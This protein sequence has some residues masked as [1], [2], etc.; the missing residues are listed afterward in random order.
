MAALEYLTQNSLTSHPF[1][2]GCAVNQ[3]NPIGADWFYDILFTSFDSSLASVYIAKIEKKENG[4]VDFT[5][6]NS[7]TLETLSDYVV[8]VSAANLVDHYKNIAKSFAYGDNS[9]FAVKLVLGPGLIAKSTF[10]QEYSKSEAE[11]SSATITMVSPRLRNLTFERY[12]SAYSILPGNTEASLTT[13]LVDVASF[14]FP[15]VP[16]ISPRYNS[17]FIEESS[18]TGILAVS[19]NA[20]AGLYNDC[21]TP[22]SIQNVYSI[23][24]VTPNSSGALFLNASSCYT[25]STLTANDKTNFDSYGYLDPYYNFEI[26]TSPFASEDRDIVSLNKTLVIQNFCKPK[27][28]PENMAAFAYYLNRVT[29]GAKELDAIATKNVETRGVGNAT[30]TNFT[31]SSFCTD[32]TFT[33]CDDS[34]SQGYIACG[35]EFIKYFHEGRTLQLY[36]TNTITYDFTIV[37]VIDSNTVRLDGTPPTPIGDNY[38]FRVVD[39]GVISNMNCAAVGYNLTAEELLNPYFKVSYTTSEAFNTAGN[40]VTYL[41]VVAALFNPSDTSKEIF[42]N[43][44][45]NAALTQ[46]GNYKV[47]D[48]EGVHVVTEPIATIPCRSYAFIEVIYYITC[49]EIG[50]QLTTSVYDVTG[51]QN[52]QIGSDYTLPGIDGAECPG[53]VAGSSIT[54]QVLNTETE[55]TFSTD[56]VDLN[57]TITSTV[58]ASSVPDWLQLTPDYDN[59]K[60]LLSLKPEQDIPDLNRNYTTYFRSYGGEVPGVITQLI[61]VYINRPT[62]IA[63][64]ELIYNQSSPLLL[65]RLTT[66]TLDLPALQIAAENMVVSLSS[67]PEEFYY[68]ATGSL[69]SG[70][71]FD[72][73][74]GKITGKLDSAVPEGYVFDLELSAHNSAGFAIN[75]QTIYFTV[76]GEGLPVMQ[77]TTGVTYAANNLITYTEGS[78]LFY[79]DATNVPIYRYNIAGNSLPAGLTVVKILNTGVITGRISELV[80]SS[81]T[82]QATAVNVYGES[83]PITFTIDYT[84]YPKPQIVSPVNLSAVSSLSVTEYLP[85]NPIVEFQVNNS[86]TGTDPTLEAASQLHFAAYNLPPGFSI[87]AATG[88]VTGQ[89]SAGTIPTGSSE[90]YFVKYSSQFVV[91]NS[92]GSTSIVVYI[93][94]SESLKPI[95]YSIANG[96][97]LPLIR[98]K[99][100]VNAD[101]ALLI[102]A[103]NLPNSYTI[104]GLPDGLASDSNAVIGLIDNLLPAGDYEVTVSATNSYGTSAVVNVLLRVPIVLIG[105]VD[106]ATLEIGQTYN[107]IFNVPNIALAEESVLIS[108]SSPP[109]GLV[110]TYSEITG[111]TLKGTPT[112]TGT[113]TFKV[114]A[115]TN[116]YG[117]SSVLLGVV[118]TTEKYSVSGRVLNDS[119]PPQ[120]VA[121]IDV[122]A[123]GGLYTSTTD[124]GGYYTVKGLSSGAYNVYASS[125]TYS[126]LPA[127]RSVTVVSSNLTNINFIA[128]GPFRLIRGKI[129]LASGSP[130]LGVTVQDNTGK[131]TTTNSFGIYELYVPLQ[132]TNT[133]TPSAATLIFA[134]VNASISAGSATVDDLDFTASALVLP[135]QLTNVAVTVSGLSAEIAFTVPLVDQTQNTS[136]EYSLDAGLTWE[137]ST[138]SLSS[139]SPIALSNLSMGEYYPITVRA[140]NL[141][142]AGPAS[143][144]IAI[145]APDVPTAPAAFTASI[146]DLNLTLSFIK[147]TARG[148]DITGYEYSLDGGATWSPSPVASLTAPSPII[149][150]NITPDTEFNIIVRSVSVIGSS[151]NSTTATV[152]SPHTPG[153]PTITTV[154]AGDQTVTFN[155]T[156]PTSTGG[157]EITNYAYYIDTVDSGGTYAAFDPPDPTRRSVTVSGLI[158]GTIYYVKLR[159]VNNLGDGPASLTRTV[160]PI[161]SPTTPTINSVTGGNGQLTVNF[162]ANSTAAAPVTSYKYSLN[163]SANWTPATLESAGIFTITGLVNGQT[164]TVKVKSINSVGETASSNS[165]PVTLSVTTLVFNSATTTTQRSITATFTLTNPAASVES[166]EYNIDGTW[167]APIPFIT[168]SPTTIT[169]TSVS[170]SLEDLVNG[171]TYLLRIRPRYVGGTYGPTSNLLPVVVRGLPGAPSIVSVEPGNAS[172]VLTYTSAASNGATISDYEYSTNGLTGTF[173]SHNRGAS[174]TPLT[175][176]QTG[177]GAALVNGTSYTVALRAKNSQGVGPAV[178]FAS[179][180]PAAP[181]TAPTITSVSPI[182][183]GADVYFTPGSINGST[184]VNYLY[185]AATGPNVVYTSFPQGTNLTSPLR[186]TGL[187]NGVTYSI[188]LKMQSAVG[189][190]EASNTVSIIPR[191][192]PGAPN[193]TQATAGVGN[194]TI[195]FTAGSTG[196][197]S[198]QAY[199]YSLST[200]SGVSWGSWVRRAGLASPIVVSSL[201]VGTNYSVRIKAENSFGETGE[202]SNVESGLIP[203]AVLGAPTITSIYPGDTSLT[204]YF[205]A[206]G[207]P[208]EPALA[209]TDYLY[210]LNGGTPVSMSRTT[211]SNVAGGYIIT[212]LTEGTSYSVTVFAKNAYGSSTSSNVVTVGVGFPSS[213]TI[214]SATINFSEN[215]QSYSATL[216]IAPP[217]YVGS[218]GKTVAGYAYKLANGGWSNSTGTGNITTG[219]LT[220]QGTTYSVV[221]AAYND[222]FSNRG[223]SSEAVSFTVPLSPAAPNITVTT[224][225][226]GTIQVDYDATGIDLYGG[227]ITG[228][229]GQKDGFALIKLGDTA[230]SYSFTDLSDDT[231]NIRVQLRTTLGYS[232]EATASITLGTAPGT[233]N[234]LIISSSWDYATGI[235]ITFPTPLES[236]A[237]DSYKYSLNSANAEVASYTDTSGTVSINIP[238]TSGTYT[239][240]VYACSGLL[241]SSASN[242]ATITVE[243]AT[244][245]SPITVYNVINLSEGAIFLDFT[246]PASNGADI[247]GYVG[248]YDDGTTSGNIS[249]SVGTEIFIY[250]LIVGS[251]CSGTLA[252]VNGNGTGTP[253]DWSIVVTTPPQD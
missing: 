131:T 240:V 252:A 247:T 93:Y 221:V 144:I 185:A 242:I 54:I 130:A 136:Y 224:P 6:G 197:S 236:E 161:S 191:G 149:I 153:A 231:Y 181:P 216:A 214:T 37:E 119:F 75:P 108:Y 145:T 166:F 49:G 141:S 77:N 43:F 17:E 245:P 53:S 55:T 98:G 79:L 71:S 84:I 29:D 4:S 122:S 15:E 137:T 59:H 114:T 127:Y 249:V 51:G 57:S 173:R 74:T 94:F 41:S 60:I 151:E 183:E 148:S 105:S 150:Q 220:Q 202:I 188:Y 186:I 201:T 226:D 66:Y 195:T 204:V 73:V 22:G 8:S 128:A 46:Q 2:S 38:P 30:L 129:L 36:Y 16:V 5:F 253:T 24:S 182:S 81:A 124:A 167:I 50:G 244:K 1:K 97:I 210:S 101:P 83:A 67:D 187:T 100:Y 125:N 172:L 103:T 230:G 25:I 243:G 169:K 194:I 113:F 92:T 189:A 20:G 160:T 138:N 143:A 225:A 112:A 104:S 156:P 62:L 196:G 192:L 239:V 52:I 32:D 117:A 134:P 222:I 109:P 61:I 118:V 9:K 152:T 178:A 11:L 215:D 179:V 68:M 170:G 99:V 45:H 63:P 212:G 251:T 175:I 232:A 228:F 199:H 250:G 164:Y 229:W 65:S 218:S 135:N 208:A 213:P 120:G 146:T 133:I 44:D 174:T 88:D 217:D 7:R 28:P 154:T 64:S 171:T 203:G 56:F 82:M 85:A 142:G 139:P 235:T 140:I 223:T 110:F 3:T 176:T 23:N 248:T 111:Y 246:P 115:T 200:N 96:Q 39:N 107:N 14:S 13:S 27:C 158:N 211:D 47:R 69:P 26:H 91:S 121:G 233:P 198:L 193:I 190:G 237:V 35:E 106:V 162:T 33:R 86:Y 157:T 227:T 78:P 168:S 126:M 102:S 34:S 80:S 234:P 90:D 19:R 206:P 163:N 40:Y 205:T 159:S 72:A 219:R 70:L 48:N 132:T 165:S 241:C 42:V 31:A 58:I 209:L 95:V 87:D 207:T 180:T 10:S 155:F 12:E 76:A 123:A 238:V 147:S 18:N 21:P 184:L 177:S 89:L 116:N